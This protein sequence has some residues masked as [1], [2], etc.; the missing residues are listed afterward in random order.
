MNLHV[1][2][3]MNMNQFNIQKLDVI[4]FKLEMKIN[5]AKIIK[6]DIMQ[7]E[8]RKICKIIKN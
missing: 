4:R 2:R 3:R 8:K 5:D 1:L 6:I 7:L